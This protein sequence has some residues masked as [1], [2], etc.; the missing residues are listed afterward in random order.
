MSRSAA[1]LISLLLVSALAS[2]SDDAPGDG[3]GA[4]PTRTGPTTPIDTCTLVSRGQVSAALGRDVEVTGRR[5]EAPTLPTE[6]CL[7]GTEFSVAV[8]EVQV[9]PGPVAGET[10][11]QAFGAGAGGEPTRVA[12]IGDAAFARTGLTSRTLQVLSHGVVLSLEAVDDPG[13]KLPAAALETLAKRAVTRL[14]ANPELADTAPAGPCA[15]VSERAVTAALD[16]R[17]ELRRA[18]AGEGGAVMC[19]WTAL[20]GNVVVTVRTDPTQVTNFRA[21][22]S[23]RLYAPVDGA[24]VEAY[25]QKQRAGDLLLF[26]GEHLIDLHVLPGEGYATQDVPPSKG[27][28]ALARELVKAFG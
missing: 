6:S 1:A 24:G 21:N 8:L 3:A 5:L 25:S 28:L 12:G 4:P 27:E 9:T 15:Q 11:D 23:P 26:A 22:L 2:C 17:P 10:F 16:A 13:D 19:S 18:R 7:W 14:P 20:P